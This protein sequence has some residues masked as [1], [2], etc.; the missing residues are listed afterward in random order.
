MAKKPTIALIYD[1][2]GTLSPGNIQE[3]GFIQAIGK[4]AKGFWKANQELSEKN[5][6]SG[7][8]CYMYMMLQKA[9]AESV[10]LSRASFQRFGKDVELFN[11]VKEWFS[12][13]NEYGKSIGVS[14]EHYINSSGLIEMI[15]GTPIAKEFKKIYACSYLYDVDGKAIWPAVAVDYTAK[16]QFLFKINKGIESI[17]DNKKIN[18]YVA[19]EER[20]IPF[21]NMIY[22]G[23]GETDIPCMKLIKGQGGHSIAVYKPGSSKKKAT[24]EKLIKEN[25]VNFV[26]P[27]DYSENKEMYKVVKTIIDKIKA[28]VEFNNLQKSHKSKACIKSVT[29]NE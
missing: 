19:E 18:E 7:I 26:C 12:L 14:I 20:P 22:F 1:F 17:S 4:D 15:E 3:F 28:D 16:T 6:A 8:L 21:R 29:D 2:D 5:D 13:I 10:S 11:G 23:D 27:A 9:N 25:R 24:A